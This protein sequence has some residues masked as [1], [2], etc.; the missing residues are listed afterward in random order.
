LE[1]TKP[2]SGNVQAEL[3]RR[4]KV[5]ASTVAG[6]LIATVLLSV[7]SLLGK[8]FF[9]QQDE[10]SLNVAVRIAIFTLGVGSVVWR[11]TK[12]SRMRLQ[13]I[14]AL[15]GAS[16]LISTLEKTT[17]QIAFLAAVIAAIGFI[18][19]LLTGNDFYTYGAGVIAVVVLLYCYPTKASWI[20]A[21]ELFAQ[22]P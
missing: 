18:S 6:L 21:V 5:A 8:R 16:G 19:T 3:E 15:Q 2:A 12:F 9:R 10:P 13:D 1:Q 20:R 17:L 22:N 7:V 4:Q 14:G 11:R